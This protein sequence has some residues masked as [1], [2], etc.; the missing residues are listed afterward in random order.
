[1]SLTTLN[2]LIHHHVITTQEDKAWLLRHELAAL[3]WH[4]AP[5]SC[6]DALRDQAFTLMSQSL[7]YKQLLQAINET[8]PLVLEIK[9]SRL[10]S[11]YPASH[12]RSRLDLDILI[13]ADESFYIDAYLKSKNWHLIKTSTYERIYRHATL[14]V[15]EC[16]H[17]LFDHSHFDDTFLNK[18]YE[19]MRFPA[20]EPH[21]DMI[22]VL[23]HGTKHIIE[24]TP[25]LKM[26]LDAY[27]IF[28]HPTFDSYACMEQ[29]STLGLRSLYETIM[30]F[31]DMI[32]GVPIELTS[33]Q[34]T[35]LTTMYQR[36]TSE[37]SYSKRSLHRFKNY[38][39]VDKLTTLFDWTM[40]A[41][42]HP[43]MTVSKLQKTHQFSSD[44]LKCL[45]ALQLDQ[46]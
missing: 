21:E 46:L 35:L 12:L 43:K 26:I 17:K 27:Y 1:M 20:I 42:R 8:Y 34:Q 36:E 22:F 4:Y 23:V 44:Y 29:C 19:T 6:D 33:T 32:D 28:H 14:G 18:V 3:A 30:L 24:G 10:G 7:T 41:L 25:Q 45:K 15:L 13:E 40:F 16:H 37:H 5:L 31:I 2:N 39:I 38:S 9:G 11:Y